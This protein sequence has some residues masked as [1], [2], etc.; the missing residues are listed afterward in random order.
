MK[1]V[2]RHLVDIPFVNHL[3]YE[4]NPDVMYYFFLIVQD[5]E[6]P[7]L[8]DYSYNNADLFKV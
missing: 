3:V 6:L 2:S 1:N 5:S 8:Q 4:L 7:I